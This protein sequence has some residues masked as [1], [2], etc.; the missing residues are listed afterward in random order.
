MN[1]D[2]YFDDYTIIRVF[3]EGKGQAFS[4][5][6]LVP[7]EVDLLVYEKRLLNQL[8]GSGVTIVRIVEEENAWL[9]KNS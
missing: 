7:L 1:V 8:K 5:L 3:F 4:R 6:L 2:N 9:L